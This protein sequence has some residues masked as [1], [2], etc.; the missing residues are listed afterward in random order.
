M[1]WT[2]HRIIFTYPIGQVGCRFHL[3]E[4]AFHLPMAIGQPLMLNPGKAYLHEQ[5]GIAYLRDKLGMPNLRDE[6]VIA[7]LHDK[8]GIAYLHDKFAKITYMTN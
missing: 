7:Y 3:P 1:N 4:D 5:L 8:L 2:Y 6:L